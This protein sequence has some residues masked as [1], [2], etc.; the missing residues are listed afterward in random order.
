MIILGKKAYYDIITND[1]GKE[2]EHYRLKAI[3][4]EAFLYYCKENNCSIRDIYIKLYNGES[5]RFDLRCGGNAFKIETKFFLA[6]IKF[7]FYR[8]I[9]FLT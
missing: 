2:E 1:T 7:N 5:V 3:S 4:K 8:E 6:D 9:K